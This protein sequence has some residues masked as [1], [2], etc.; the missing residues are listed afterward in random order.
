M[1]CQE[2]QYTQSDFTP[3]ATPPQAF[4]CQNWMIYLLYTLNP[5]FCVLKYRLYFEER[6]NGFG[7]TKTQEQPE[8]EEKMPSLLMWMGK[9]LLH[10]MLQTPASKDTST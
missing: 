2:I 4:P 3:D 7:T 8:R 1:Q 9:K 10:C 5:T 6:V